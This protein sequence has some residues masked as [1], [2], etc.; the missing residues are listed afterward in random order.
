MAQNDFVKKMIKVAKNPKLYAMAFT[1][2]LIGLLP[3]NN[4][5]LT[6]DPYWL[7]VPLIFI[8]GCILFIGVG[9]FLAD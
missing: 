9:V 6:L 1:V 7:A 2:S 5:I 3:P 8:V 4:P